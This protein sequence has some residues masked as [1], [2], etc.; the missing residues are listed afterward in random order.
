MISVIK[1]K[2]IEY[3][4]REGGAVYKLAQRKNKCFKKK[5]DVHE[6]GTD[7]QGKRYAYRRT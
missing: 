1:A 5:D 6:P 7:R 2:A 3:L 4:K